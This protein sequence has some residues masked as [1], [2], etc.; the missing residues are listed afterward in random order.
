MKPWIRSLRPYLI[1]FLI[2]AVLVI[3]SGIISAQSNTITKIKDR[4][5]PDLAL[6][7][8]P[9]TLRMI[10]LSNNDDF[11]HMVRD[12]Q[13]MRYFQWSAENFQEIDE[14]NLI[15]DLLEENFEECMSIKG[16][17]M[18][19]M[20]Y[21]HDQ[22]RKQPELIAIVKTGDK[23]QMLDIQGMVNVTKIPDLIN[24][25]NADDFFNVLDLNKNKKKK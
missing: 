8:Y 16:R 6:Y 18:D 3:R 21:G 17:E 25:L 9:S 19:L 15:R 20:V 1:L 4:Q 24:S 22:H 23:V 12:I 5:K 7:F 13:K 10:N 11:D 2:T 14:K